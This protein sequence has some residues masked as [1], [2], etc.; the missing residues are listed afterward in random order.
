MTSTGASETL[1]AANVY[2]HPGSKVLDY[3][4]VWGNPELSLIQSTNDAHFGA[5]GP[6]SRVQMV[7]M[8]N[9]YMAGLGVP[10]DLIYAEALTQPVA[11]LKRIVWE[12]SPDSEESFSFTRKL[13]CI[14][15]L[16]GKFGQIEGVLID[17]MSTVYRDKGFSPD[18]L[19]AV[20]NAMP[21]A[22][23]GWRLRLNGVVYTMS[24]NDPGVADLIDPLDVIMLPIWAVEDAAQLEE[25]VA[26]TQQLG[27][28]KPIIACLYMYNYGGK[29]P[30]TDQI[31][32]SQFSTA[33]SLLKAGKVF[34]IEVTL[35]GAEN[36]S[37]VKWL[38]QWVEQVG[39][40][41]LSL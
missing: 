15:E 4:W 1:C 9:V 13:E 14:D 34:G 24:L 7:G 2:R 35:H 31:M 39:N 11:H 28:G 8:Q 27:P 18:A 21:T 26:H 19:R 17:D 29:I 37:A 5:A 36:P 22:P 30:I 32:D 10:Y 16:A 40:E 6:I 38:R 20:A 12:I 3:L 23:D 41:P 25:Y 33:L